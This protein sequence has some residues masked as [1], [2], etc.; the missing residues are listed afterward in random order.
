VAELDTDQVLAIADQLVAMQ[1]REVTLIG[2]EAY[3]RDDLDQ[4]I[5]RLASQG[6]RVTMQTGGRGLTGALC[7]RLKR[8][9]LSAIG[10]SIDGPARVHDVLRASP[11]SHRSGMRALTAAREAGLVITANTQINRLNKDMLRETCALLTRAGVRVWRPQLTVP[12]GRAAD[13]PEWI[14]AP[15][16]ILEVIDTLAALQIEA[17]EA[18]QAAGLEPSEFLDILAGNNIGYFG[19]HEMLLRSH[20]GQKAVHWTGCQAGRYTLG[21]EADGTVK[22][23]PSL[24]TAPYNGGKI[25]ET[26]LAEIWQYASALQFT[27]ERDLSEL[28]GFCATCYYAEQCQAGCSFT[29]HCTLGRRGN[30]PF[31]YHRAATLRD[32]GIRET[33]VHQEKPGGDA[34][35]F[36]RFAIVEEPIRIVEEP[37]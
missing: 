32:R 29:A 13:R 7:R 37:I 20:P 31:C 15:W 19:P 3:L 16:H 11:G 35:D 1:A 6:V 17:A 4:V 8:A 36:G 5:T 34:Y 10:V 24:P 21:I 12:M 33:L 23:C 30:Q 26:P 27:R 14:L 28:W 25:T 18:G 2:G 9:G 22:A